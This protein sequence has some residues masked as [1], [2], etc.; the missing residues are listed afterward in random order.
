MDARSAH[1]AAADYA[2]KALRTA[3]GCPCVAVLVLVSVAGLLGCAASD[4]RRTEQPEERTLVFTHVTVIDA[5]GAPPAD[6]RTVV[7]AGEKIQSVARSGEVSVPENAT[8][9]DATGKFLI[10]GLWDM[11]VHTR[12]QG[13][14]FFGLFLANGITAVRDMGGP[15]KQFEKLKRARSD[16]DEQSAPVPRIVAAGR[17]L[18]G[19]GSPWSHA[20]IVEGPEEGRELVRRLKDEGADLVKVSSLLS[21]DTFFAILD[22]AKRQGL[23]FGGHVPGAVSAAEAS[24]AGQRTIEHLS[25]VLLGCS[26]EEESLRQRWH[27]SGSRPDGSTLL[28][29][30]DEEKA[31]SLIDRFVANETWHVPTLASAWTRLRA[32]GGDARVTASERL[33]YLPAGYRQATSLGAPSRPGALELQQRVLEKQLEL[34]GQMHAAGVKLLAGTDTYKPFL[35]PGFSLHDELALLV[36]AGL[37]PLEAL[38]TATRNPAEHLGLSDLGTVEAGKLADLVLLDANPLE[39]IGNTMQIAAV[40]WRGRILDRSALEALRDEAREAARNRNGEPT[41]IP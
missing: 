23:P 16:V 7:V 28:E 31:S 26:R 17:L 4:G 2:M 21:R 10:P 32:R 9:V 22:E 38:Q 33:D 25:G 12:Y 41:S 40:V 19:P 30:Y 34:V 11:H 36:K 6:D 5:T 18:A 8:V 20:A 27:D 24:D 29:T 39:D 37:T 14:D 35:V 15:W 13:I 3:A 1:R